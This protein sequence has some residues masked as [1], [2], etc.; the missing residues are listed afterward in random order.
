MNSKL[1]KLYEDP[2]AYCLDSQ[3]GVLRW[4]GQRAFQ[5]Q[6]ERYTALGAANSHRKI[7]VIMTAYNTGGLVAEA[8]Q[9]VLAQSHSDLELMVMDDA[10]SDDTLAV[11]KKLAATDARMRVFH[12]PVNHGTY[13]SKNWC[14]SKADGEFVAFHDSDDVSDPMRLQMQVGAMLDGKRGCDAVT[15]RWQRVNPE[16]QLLTID[17]AVSRTSVISMMIR[18]EI[19]LNKVGY[20]DTVRIAADTEYKMRITKLLGHN[21]LRN[22]RHVLYTGLLRDQSLTR[23]EQGGFEWRTE[24]LAITRS[25]S[26]NRADYMQA[27]QNWHK[28]EQPL[29]VAFPQKSRPFVAPASICGAC[30]DM[31]V[32]QVVE[33]TPGHG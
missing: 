8:V 10:S 6:T 14:L 18:R 25:L 12:S 15:C 2:V 11:L 22:M 27:F 32:S 7:T 9:S 5:K 13:W 24:G 20:F 16:G 29:Y 28:S 19:V 26:G 30:D 21:R 4:L 3:H 33:V 23:G 1:R 17:G 31:D